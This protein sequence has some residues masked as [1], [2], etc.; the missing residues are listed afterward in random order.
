[1]ELND[2]VKLL[3]QSSDPR[4]Q[5]IEQ[6]KAPKPTAVINGTQLEL[7]FTMPSGNIVRYVYPT[8]LSWTWNTTTTNA[9]TGAYIY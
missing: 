4:R 6:A 7:P 2:L 9:I 8:D 3:E 1:M 5:A